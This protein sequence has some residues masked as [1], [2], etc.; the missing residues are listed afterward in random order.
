MLELVVG[1]SSILGLCEAGSA[2]TPPRCEALS[3]AKVAHTTI[4]SA[5]TVAAGAFQMPPAPAMGGP[6]ADF[7]SLPAF[8][9][10][11]GSIRPSKDSDI[12]F[13]LWLPVA[14]WNGKF[15]QTGNGGAAGSIV[16]SSFAEPLARGFAVANTDTGHVGSGGDFG[17]AKGHPEKITDYSYRAVHEL[18]I[19]GKSL[20]AANYGTAPRKSYWDGCSTGGRQGLKE[21]QRYPQ[22]YDAILA[23]A[24]ASNWS[25]LMSL[26]ILIQRNMTGPGGLG[27]D[28]LALLTEAALA[29]CDAN[30]GVKDRIIADSKSCHFNPASLVCKQGETQQCLSPSDVAAAQRIYG[31]VVTDTG[32]VL[33]PGTGPASEALWAAYASPQ[34]SI[35]TSYF[36]N[37]VTQDP[38]WTPALFEVDRDVKRAEELDQGRAAAMDPDLSKFIAH[39]GKLLTYH[40][41]ADGLISYGNSVNYYESVVAKLGQEKV[42]DNVRLYLVPGMSHCSGG[43]GAY[44]IDWLGALDAWSETGNAP[45]TLPASHPAS[46]PGAPGFAALG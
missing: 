15:V 1:L 37:V 20:I 21:A 17:W 44:M 10:V 26:S 45:G 14:N 36:R 42:K 35:G 18:T 4:T 9:R 12:R 5:V 8:C 13:E 25:P 41:T 28:K 40:G 24:P 34:F 38:N 7:S 27:V 39:G 46:A 23:G 22:D 43:E 2:D 16:Y 3:A 32:K 31:G 30:D 11:T 33:M 6:P 19:V 29:S